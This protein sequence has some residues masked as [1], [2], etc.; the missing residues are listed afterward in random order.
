MTATGV[1]VA[2]AHADGWGWCAVAATKRGISG[3]VIGAS[4]R[5]AA[6]S[7]VKDSLADREPGPARARSGL[8]AL[9]AA[10]AGQ[11]GKA[12]ALDLAGSPFQQLVWRGLLEIGQGE[13]VSYAGLARQI[14]RTPSSARAVGSA[15]GANPA[16]VLVPCHRVTP[17]GGGIGK[18]R[19]GSVLKERL[20]AAERRA[21]A[22]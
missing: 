4:D 21:A 6:E 10:L 8:D 19:L 12:V 7:A 14:G 2:S 3:T 18:Y 16:P 22:P 9:L 17:A 5:L 20:L 15:V 1:G 13:T 11:G